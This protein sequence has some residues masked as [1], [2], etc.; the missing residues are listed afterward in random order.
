[1]KIKSDGKLHF[2]VGEIVRVEDRV[3][4][5][6]PA[7]CQ[8]RCAL[9]DYVS[10]DQVCCLALERDDHQSVMFINAKIGEGGGK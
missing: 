10:C 4:K 5:C 7:S 9:Q 3:L 8:F 6:V 1:M 2:E